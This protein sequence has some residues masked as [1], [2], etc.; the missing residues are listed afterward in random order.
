MPSQLPSVPQLPA[1]WS[2]HW[3][4]GSCPAGTVEQVP[5]V[6]DSA[7]DMQLPRQAVWQQTPCSQKPLPQ[8]AA[9]PHALPSGR[10]P[11]LPLVQ[12]L[13]VVQSLEPVHEARHPP[14][15]PHI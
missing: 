8:S 2:V 4:S 1:P 10:L 15:V 3:F 5:P 7:H 12:T 11:Q 6:P 13:P 14:V 9:A